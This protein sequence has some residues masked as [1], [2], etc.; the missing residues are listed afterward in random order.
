MVD[1]LGLN[2]PGI[3]PL[4]HRAELEAEAKQVVGAFWTAVDGFLED[5][6]KKGRPS[7]Q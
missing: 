7:R 5:L 6:G 3:R 2:F 1:G 4:G